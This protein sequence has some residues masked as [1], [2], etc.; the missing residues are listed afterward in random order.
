[1]TYHHVTTMIYHITMTTYYDNYY[2]KYY[3][4][5]RPQVTTTSLQQ[6]TA[7]FTTMWW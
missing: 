4:T 5:V 6:V 7:T 1:M 2:D 3:D